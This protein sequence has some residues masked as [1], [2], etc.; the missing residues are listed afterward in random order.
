VRQAHEAYFAAFE[1]VIADEP[2]KLSALDDLEGEALLGFLWATDSAVETLNETC[3]N[4]E[5]E[6]VVRRLDVQL[7][8]N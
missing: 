6:A 4:L 5:L 8:S 1:A 7:C 3:A 2:N